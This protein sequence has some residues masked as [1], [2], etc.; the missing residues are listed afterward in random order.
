MPSTES[1]VSSLP[2]LLPEFSSRPNRSVRCPDPLKPINRSDLPDQVT[3]RIGQVRSGFVAHLIQ[4]EFG[5]SLLPADLEKIRDQLPAI[6]VDADA[7]ISLR[8]LQH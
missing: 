2:Y 5:S 1:P 6:R 7:D 3:Q 4:L 8:G